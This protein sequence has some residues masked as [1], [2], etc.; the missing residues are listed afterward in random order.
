[1]EVATY[2]KRAVQVNVV[3][4]DRTSETHLADDNVT[5]TSSTDSEARRKA[6]TETLLIKSISA[7]PTP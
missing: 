1:M 5:I 3:T 4:T 6:G 7:I 2:L